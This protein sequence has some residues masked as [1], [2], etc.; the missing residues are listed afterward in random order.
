MNIIRKA[1][2]NFIYSDFFFRL[3]TDYISQAVNSRIGSAGNSESGLFQIVNVVQFAQMINQLL[4]HGSHIRLAL[5][6]MKMSSNISYFQ[7]SSLHVHHKNELFFKIDKKIELISKKEKSN[8]EIK[9]KASILNITIFKRQY[10]SHEDKA[11]ETEEENSVKDEES[12]EDSQ[13]DK[14]LREKFNEFKPLLNDLK[15]SI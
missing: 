8:F 1:V 4:F 13:E 9:F 7:G 11:L 12:L 5:K 14:S 15:N 3:K 2:I 6:S 10:P